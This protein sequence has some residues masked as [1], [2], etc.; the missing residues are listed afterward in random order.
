MGDLGFG[1]NFEKGNN[2]N[3]VEFGGFKFGGKPSAREKRIINVE[4]EDTGDD[5]IVVHV[6]ESVDIVVDI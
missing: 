2:I 1:G 4:D 5:R 6:E 3:N